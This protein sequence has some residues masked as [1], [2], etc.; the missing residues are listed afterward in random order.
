MGRQDEVV[1]APAAG[2][3]DRMR[4]LAPDH[5]QRREHDAKRATSA[6]RHDLASGV[7]SLPDPVGV[8]GVVDDDVV[9]GCAPQPLVPAGERVRLLDRRRRGG[10]RDAE[11]IGERERPGDVEGVVGAGQPGANRPRAGSLG[12]LDL[13]AAELRRDGDHPPLRFGM[14]AERDHRASQFAKVTREVAAALLVDADRGRGDGGAVADEEPSLAVFVLLD[15]AMTVE[16]V[17]GE[18]REDRGIG[19]ELRTALELEAGE[20]TDDHVSRAIGGGGIG[21]SE[22]R[23][24]GADRR[25]AVGLEDGGDQRDGG[26]LAVG[27]GNRQ[28]RAGVQAPAEL[29]LV[30][31][32]EPPPRGGVE[33][34]RAW[35][36]PGALDHGLRRRRPVE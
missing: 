11:G 17:V 2:S 35:R 33:D 30:D 32:R 19:K 5:G 22:G 3:A 1:G 10:R 26:A 25:T 15:G 14:V 31:H 12:D 34:R 36:Q 24:P 16:V 21:D 29:R 8:V 23:V 18:V 4:L 13:S 6:R 7:E 20:L 27:S 9:P 28:Q